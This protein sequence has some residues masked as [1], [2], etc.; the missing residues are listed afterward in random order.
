MRWVYTLLPAFLA[1][2]FGN[3]GFTPASPPESQGADP[4][5]VV[6]TLPVYAALVRQIGGG[7]VEV[8]AIANPNEDSHFVRPRPSF[9]RDLRQAD[10][11]I[12]T[13]LDLE[14]WVPVLLDRAGNRVV[15]EGGRGYVTAHTGIDLL[16]VPSTVDR[17][18]G[19][20]HIF[21]NPHLTTDPVRTL[22]VARNITRGLVRV[23]PDRRT[24]W[25]AGLLNFQRELYD[26]LFGAELVELLG[27]ETLEEL[28]KG[29]AL[30]GF[31]E[32]NEIDG[33]P[34]IE[35]LGGWLGAGLNFRGRDLI[36]YHKNWS[37]LEERFGIQCVDFVEP[38]PGIPP[39]PAHVVELVKR[40]TDENIRVVLAASYFSSRKVEAVTRRSDGIP[41]V[42]P[43]NPG[44][45][46]NSN[47][48]F[49]LVDLWVDSL[50]E[51]FAAADAN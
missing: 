8:S 50:N 30:I 25:E 29:N 10:L 5:R 27:G 48:Y 49:S 47:D 20:V 44:A 13:G 7:E 21:G 28:A 6:T 42:V 33:S 43:M 4:V 22:Q 36:C 17:S 38:K 11:F 18:G 31:L 15:S 51:A 2:P 14:L 19:D 3:P 1:V 12:T 16:D 34:L 40:M 45:S 24:L 32:E 39:S 35:R 9:A 41:V 26:R 23:A 37:Y 46:D